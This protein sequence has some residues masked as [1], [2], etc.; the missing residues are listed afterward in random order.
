M[1]MNEKEIKPCPFCGGEKILFSLSDG[2]VSASCPCGCSLEIK[3]YP[4][5]NKKR[6]ACLMGG[7]NKRITRIGAVS[8]SS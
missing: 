1:K 7:W 4:S 6:L 3:R 8:P 5:E 2:N